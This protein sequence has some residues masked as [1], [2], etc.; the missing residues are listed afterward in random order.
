MRFD[1]EK[2]TQKVK[3]ALEKAQVHTVVSEVVALLDWSWSAQG[4][5]YDG[6]MQ[7][8]VQRIVP[9]AL[10]FDDNGEIPVYGFD[11][12]FV[13]LDSDLNDSN[14]ENYIKKQILEGRFEKWGSTC[15]EPA[16][17]QALQDLGFYKEQK[18]K[19]FGL[20]GG[21]PPVLGAISTSGIPALIYLL[22]DGENSDQDQTRKLLQACAREK[23]SAYFNMVGIG[24]HDFGFLRSVA[25]ELPNVGFTS[26]GDLAKTAASDELYDHLL[27]PE[28]LDWLKGYVKTS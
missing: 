26:I 22:S 12:D 24:R 4:L 5:Y 1:I 21:G 27:P 2:E 15:Y 10:N 20:F 23:T 3:F 14:Y 7:E 9:I 18:G 19:F 25:D 17:R 28:L 13:R 16:L 6:H 8:A 11:D